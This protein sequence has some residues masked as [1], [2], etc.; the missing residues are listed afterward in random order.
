MQG[1][2]SEGQPAGVFFFMAAGIEQGSLTSNS[3]FA[4]VLDPIK[5]MLLHQ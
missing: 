4:L 3:V 2:H 5:H 1:P